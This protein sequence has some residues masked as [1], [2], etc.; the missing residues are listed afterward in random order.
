[1]D[2]ATADLLD[3]SEEPSH[4]KQSDDEARKDSDGTFHSIPLYLFGAILGGEGPDV[5]AATTYPE[6]AEMGIS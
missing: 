1:V 2:K 3:Q 4:Y 6:V 5:K